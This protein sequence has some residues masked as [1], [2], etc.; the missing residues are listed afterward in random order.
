MNL[1]RYI[2]T[3]LL[4]ATTVALLLSPAGANTA[5]QDNKDQTDKPWAIHFAVSSGFAGIS[6]SASLNNKGE[7]A[8]FVRGAGRVCFTACKVQVE[9]AGRLM[10]QLGLSGPPKTI[11][12]RAEIPDLPSSSFTADSGGYTYD[13]DTFTNSSV[14]KKLFDIL[15]QV[16]QDG[17]DRMAAKSSEDVKRDSAP[18]PA[19]LGQ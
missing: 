7:A 6:E 18:C 9:K 1:V 16:K 15:S 13:L 5:L 11:S 10:T 3:R 12:K 4:V 8:V 17:Q 14:R 19:R 2:T